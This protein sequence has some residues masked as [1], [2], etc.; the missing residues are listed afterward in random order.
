MFAKFENGK[1]TIVKAALAED[2]DPAEW[3]KVDASL[4]GTR[5]VKDGKKVRAIT[6]EE[7][8]AEREAAHAA[9]Q[10]SL[11]KEA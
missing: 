1:S 2:E 11:S 7:I 3:T 5:L 10:A 9:Y 6:E 4:A 8:V